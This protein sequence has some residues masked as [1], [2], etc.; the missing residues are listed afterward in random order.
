[1]SL[2]KAQLRKVQQALKPLNDQVKKIAH[3]RDVLREMVSEYEDILDS[4]DTGTETMEDA[5]EAMQRGLDE[6]STSL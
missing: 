1:M 4:L 5:V 2:T 3:E 6:I